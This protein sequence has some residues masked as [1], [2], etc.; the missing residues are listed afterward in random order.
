MARSFPVFAQFVS[1]GGPPALSAGN[2]ATEMVPRDIQEGI[3]CGLFTVSDKRLVFD[4]ILGP[5]IMAFHTVTNANVLED[6]S[7][8]LA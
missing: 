6:Y 3:A 5:V 8:R 4:L 1:R 2:S 7:R